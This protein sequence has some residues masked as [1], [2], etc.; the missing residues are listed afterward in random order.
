[1]RG[2][3]KAWAAPF[4][5]DHPELAIEHIDSNDP[6]FAY[7][8]LDLEIGM[9]KGDFMIERASRRDAHFLGLERDVSIQGIA[10]KKIVNAEL[11]N[12]KVCPHDFDFVLEELNKLRF[13]RIYL[14]F[15]DP[16]PKKKHAKRRL[17]Y[18]PRLQEIANLLKPNGELRIKTDNDSLYSFTLEQIPLLKGV[19]MSINEEAYVF[20]SSDDSMSEYERNFR[21]K[22]QN[23]HRIFLIKE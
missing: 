21:E 5:N 4:L 9:G 18:A 19:K 15:S 10:A 1:M 16:W 11:T 8:T 7:P 12:I 6:F 13:D 17:T 23:I 20:D 14:N 22:G 2:R 3:H